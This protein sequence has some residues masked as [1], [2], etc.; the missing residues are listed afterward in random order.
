MYLEEG[1]YHKSYYSRER[2]YCLLA[3]DSVTSPIIKL[4]AW[5]KGYRRLCMF[6]YCRT[7]Y[8]AVRVGGGGGVPDVNMVCALHATTQKAEHSAHGARSPSHNYQMGTNSQTPAA[9]LGHHVST[10]MPWESNGSKR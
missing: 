10:F 9:L 3:L 2:V 6:Y 1:T 7:Y 5:G 8:K 4:S